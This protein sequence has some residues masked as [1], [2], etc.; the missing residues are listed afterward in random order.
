MDLCGSNEK[1]QI[2]DHS[3]WL[4]FPI[5]PKHV[6]KLAS[7]WTNRYLNMLICQIITYKP[8]IAFVLL[9]RNLDFIP[10]KKLIKDECLCGNN[11]WA[12]IITLSW[13]LTRH[14]RVWVGFLIVCWN[15]IIKLFSPVKAK[16]AYVSVVILM[17][18]SKRFFFQNGPFFRNTL[19][20]FRLFFSMVCVTVFP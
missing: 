17:S 3:R 8:L 2:F 1:I 11:C 4:H 18:V 19:P 20:L 5:F 12:I 13:L 16:A 14:Q 10:E 15:R 7:D 6:E 9:R